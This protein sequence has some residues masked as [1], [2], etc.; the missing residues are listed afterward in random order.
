MNPLHAIPTFFGQFFILLAVFVTPA[1]L[2][3]WLC[4]TLGRAARALE[5]IAFTLRRMDQNRPRPAA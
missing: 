3:W 4:S 2:V 1:L 5:E